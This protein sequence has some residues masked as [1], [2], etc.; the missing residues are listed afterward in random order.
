MLDDDARRKVVGV[1]CA[2]LAIVLLLIVAWPTNA[3]VSKPSNTGNIA[4][5][6]A[7]SRLIDGDTSTRMLMSKYTDD[8][9]KYPPA[10][11]D[12]KTNITFC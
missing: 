7:L 1:V 4:S 3:V 10:T 6:N 11:I 9:G 12:T 5:T 2:V 8:S